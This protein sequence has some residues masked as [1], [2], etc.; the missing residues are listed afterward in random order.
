MRCDVVRCAQDWFGLR[1][2]IFNAGNYRRKF[3]EGRNASSDLFDPMNAEVTINDSRAVVVDRRE[4]FFLCLFFC[5][6]EENIKSAS[7]RLAVWF[8]FPVVSFCDGR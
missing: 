7:T 5:E 1:T 6:G 2:E 3:P 8:S 4:M